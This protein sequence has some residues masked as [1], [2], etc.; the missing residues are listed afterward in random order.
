ME[1]I[2]GILEALKGT[3]YS[4]WRKIKAGI[5]DYY[6]VESIKKTDEI[7]LADPNTIIPFI[8]RYCST[9]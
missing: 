3:S 9:I 4:E 1:K 6:R 7:Q 2:N 8:K 5:D